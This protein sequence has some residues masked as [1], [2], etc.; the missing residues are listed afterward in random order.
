MFDEEKLVTFVGLLPCP[1]RIPITELFQEFLEQNKNIIHVDHELKAASTGADWIAKNIE[2]VKKSSELPDIFISAGYEAFFD[3]KKE[4][5]NFE[6]MHFTIHSNLKKQIK[7]LMEL[8]FL[9]PR[10]YIR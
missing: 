9:I 8:N 2:N 4:L 7:T 10:E 3:K 5:A 6:N 1:V